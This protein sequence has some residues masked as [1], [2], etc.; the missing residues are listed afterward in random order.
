VKE[1]EGFEWIVIDRTTP[2]GK[3]LFKCSLCGV[4]Q[5]WPDK[6]KFHRCQEKEVQNE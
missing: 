4:E 6:Y 2:S 1:P 3:Q 5:P